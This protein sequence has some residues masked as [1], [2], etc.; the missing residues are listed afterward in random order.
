M[1]D[2]PAHAGSRLGHVATPFA[3]HLDLKVERAEAGE[4]VVSLDLRPE[5][6]S[7][8]GAGHAGVIMTLL[9]NAMT[10]AALS[11]QAYTREVLT[12]DMRVGLMRAAQGRLVATG[13][14]IG[15]GKSVCFCE[16][17]LLDES[18]EIRA[19]AMGTYRYEGPV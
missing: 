7:T 12:V 6:L 8:Q 19:Q 17:N 2:H 4:A 5:L 15:G 16:A 14:A 13:R 10:H 9:D 11:R 1:N 18:G 3:D